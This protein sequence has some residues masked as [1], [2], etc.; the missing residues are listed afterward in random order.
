MQTFNTGTAL[1]RAAQ[2]CRCSN[3][4]GPL[5]PGG[6]FPPLATVWSHMGAGGGKVTSQLSW[7][8]GGSTHSSHSQA[9][10]LT[11]PSSQARPTDCPTRRLLVCVFLQLVRRYKTVTGISLLRLNCWLAGHLHYLFLE[12]RL[13]VHTFVPESKAPVLRASPHRHG[14]GAKVGILSRFHG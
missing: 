12:F 6:A 14:S 4:H 2:C 1:Q 7:P 13:E 9:S 8:W 10:V 3:S 5:E 11:D